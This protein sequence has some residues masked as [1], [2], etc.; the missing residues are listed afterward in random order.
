[1][2]NFSI[3]DW[4][5]EVSQLEVCEERNIIWIRKGFELVEE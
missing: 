2:F 5:K 4:C 3:D 1:M